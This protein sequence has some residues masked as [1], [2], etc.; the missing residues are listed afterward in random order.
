M[1]G[2]P[3]VSVLTPVYNG[4]QF[5][6]ECIGSVL[7]QT[8][9]N[10]EYVIVDNSSTDNTSMIA[11]RFAAQDSRVRVIHA[12]EFLDIYGNHNRA[13][14]EVHPDSRF[15]KVVQADDWIYPECLERM[16]GLAESHPSVGIVSAFALNVAHVHLDGV[17]P[18][19]QSVMPG[20]EAARRMLRGTYF[21]WIVGG[22]TSILMR[23]D[24]VRGERDF[25]DAG[26]PHADS[27]AAVEALMRSDLG[28]V[29][30]VLTFMRGDNVR[31]LTLSYAY[32]LLT[33]LPAE[34]RLLARFGPRVLSPA[35]YRHHMRAWLRRY[36]LWISK[37]LV[38]SS[39]RRDA[40]FRT[41]HHRE[42]DAILSRAEGDRE[43]QVVLRVLRFVLDSAPG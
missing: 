30:Q 42:I 20:R 23:A 14:R 33:L 8:Y 6:A 25:Y 16:V 36:G 32:R 35:E 27:E 41:F 9:T 17:V 15:C 3:V 24:L 22:P 19:W 38:K 13:L 5:L 2:D 12:T 28:F 40:E 26:V 29:H 21:D 31:G 39:R 37:Q 7:R 11:D 1:A 4:E 10:F 34:G 43:A 18:Y